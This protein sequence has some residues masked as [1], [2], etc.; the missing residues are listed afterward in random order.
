MHKPESIR[1]NDTYKILYD[2]E[3]ETDHLIPARWPDHVLIRKKKKKKK[4]L[5]YNGFC[6]SSGPHSENKR[7]QNERQELRPEK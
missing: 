6:G 7:N 5:P 2:F 4:N 3:I 1:E